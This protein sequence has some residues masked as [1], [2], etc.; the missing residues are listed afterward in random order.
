MR[1]VNKGLILTLIV[2]LALTIY[3]LNVEQ[4]RKADK[5]NIKKICE[6][7]ISFTDKYTILPIDI[8]TSNETTKIT[9]IEEYKKE[10]KKELEKFM[11]S[12]ENAVNLQYKFLESILSD[13]Y[14]ELSVTTKQTRKINKIT[15]YKFDGN[16]VTVKFQNNFERTGKIF[17]ENDAQIINKAFD[18]YDDE[19]ILQK[20]DGR[21]KIV[22]SNLQFEESDRYYDDDVTIMY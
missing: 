22:Y 12:N 17:N 21:W 8:Q 3:I 6:Q 15:E 9:K 11:I 10:L 5:E 14:N 7:F 19:I 13:G 4:Q 1:K 2:L 18:T 16:K 20:V